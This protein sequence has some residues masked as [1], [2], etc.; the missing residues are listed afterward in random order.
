M[1]TKLQII[2]EK[3]GEYTRERR[4][5]YLRLKNSL[6]YKKVKNEPVKVEPIRKNFQYSKP[7]P[8]KKDSSGFKIFFKWLNNII[9]RLT[10][11]IQNLRH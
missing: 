9:S 4:K 3:R 7:S 5:N 2:Q 11:S 1:K 8:E 6:K 10:A